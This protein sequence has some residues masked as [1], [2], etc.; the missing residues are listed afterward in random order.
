MVGNNRLVT[1]RNVLLGSGAAIASGLAGCS[2]GNGD[3][4]GQFGASDPLLTHDRWGKGETAL[5]YRTSDFY[6]PIE[7]E[8]AVSPFPHRSWVN[9]GSDAPNCPLPSPFP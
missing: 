2:Q 4:S 3:G 1:R 7:E 5:T 6:T 8:S 9:R